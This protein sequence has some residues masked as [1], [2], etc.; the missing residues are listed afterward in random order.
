MTN[1]FVLA[2]LCVAVAGETPARDA[3]QLLH[4]RE[5]VDRIDD[6][7][8]VREARSR[9]AA[10]RSG[11][12]ATAQ[13]PN[14]R[15]EMTAGE[16]Q[17]ADGSLKKTEWAVTLTIPLEWAGT[18]GPKVDAA[19]AAAQGADEEARLVR[20]EALIR[21]RRLFVEVAHND[22]LVASL[23]SS[24]RQTEELAR[25]V[26]R[27][28]DSGEARPPE[29][30]RI[31]VEAERARLALSLAEARHRVRREQLALWLGRPVLGVAL[32]LGRTSEPPPLSEVKDGLVGRQPRVRAAQARV[33]GSAE[34]LRA[35]RNQRVPT[36]SV[37][38]YV[39]SE[40]DRRAVGG[41]LGVAAPIWN[42]NGGGIARATA[43]EAAESSRLEA[44]RIEAAS[45]LVE[46]WT[47]CTQL[48]D[49]SARLRGEVIPRAE[50]AASKVERAFQLGEASLLEVLD[51]RR[52]FLEVQREALGAE[53]GQQLECGA[54]T[55]LAGGDLR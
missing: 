47:M 32:D 40:V 14:P 12:D 6:D 10:A 29:L 4:W 21:L 51:A 19:R 33:S 13:V 25:L 26:K 38:G 55:I 9:S 37:G 30:P 54:L 39:L 3:S 31:E 7:P 16:G 48:R 24:A 11:A 42:W 18:R 27:R 20:Q 17:T 41:A 1:T 53:L 2:V 28:V 35:E 50:L 34:E 15:W 49:A 36:V 46:T 23:A 22:R 45:S 52:A 43:T 5:V 44:V 8:L